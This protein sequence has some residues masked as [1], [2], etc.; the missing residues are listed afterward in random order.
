MVAGE[1]IIV[2]L[3]GLTGLFYT[4]GGFAGG[5]MFIAILLLSG[6]PPSQTAAAG[7][8]F[9]IFSTISSL[10]RWRTHVSRDLLWFGVGSVPAAF[11]SGSLILPDQIMK[12]IM[13]ISI[14][15]GG[16]SI[17]IATSPL[18]IVKLGVP[19]KIVVGIIIGIIAGLTGIG[20]G[21]YLAPLLILGGIAQPKN[22]A[23][24]TT[25]FIMLNSVAGVAAR[26]PRLPVL[27]PNPSL[28]ITIPVVILAAQLG[29]YLGSKRLKEIGVKRVIGAILITVGAYFLFSSA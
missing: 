9:N 27:L 22:T 5:S 12:I 10:A 18:R 24:T 1:L 6:Q 25:V 29:S 4:M 15:I 8:I 16:L 13:G 19:L 11:F 28:L 2:S 26:A 14:A 20:G 23:A 17:I 7:L 21:V 3:L